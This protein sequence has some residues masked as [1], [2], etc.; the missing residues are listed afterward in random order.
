MQF[1]SIYA[2]MSSNMQAVISS[3]R[4][5]I[6][7]MQNSHSN[8][9]ALIQALGLICQQ[10]SPVQGE[11]NHYHQILPALFKGVDCLNE[12]RLTSLQAIN[13]TIASAPAVVVTGYCD[14]IVNILHEATFSHDIR[15]RQ[16]ALGCLGT[17]ANDYYGSLGEC[18]EALMKVTF[19]AMK[20]DVEPVAVKAIEFWQFISINEFDIELRRGPSGAQSRHL[21]KGKHAA[22]VDAL[23]K[24]L[25]RQHVSLGISKA[26]L[27]PNYRSS[28]LHEHGICSE[29]CLCVL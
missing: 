12:S 11:T 13:N 23:L 1:L 14:R 15:I 2:E 21:V 27:V 25:K 5:N 7:L 17:I 26:A 22:L 4:L 6:D 8:M 28:T 16:E 9:Q 19:K 10:I 29:C 24:T 20:N 18:N 3:L